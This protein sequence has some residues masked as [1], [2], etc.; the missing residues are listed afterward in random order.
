MTN[1]LIK[2][3]EEKLFDT[4]HPSYE[5]LQGMYFG[6]YKR[7]SE[8]P[9]AALYKKDPEQFKIQFGEFLE[10]TVTE[11]REGYLKRL[12]SDI[13]VNRKKTSRSSY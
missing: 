6:E 7:Q 11:D 10:K 13:V 5:Q 8:G 12:L 3:L 1:R 9:G 4:G 2:L